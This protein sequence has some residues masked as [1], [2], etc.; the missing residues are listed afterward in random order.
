LSDG[1]IP[2]DA[3]LWAKKLAQIDEHLQGL[4]YHL[5]EMKKQVA[6]EKE[7]IESSYEIQRLA[8]EQYAHLTEFILQNLPARLP[9]R[10]AAV[11][12]GKEN[13]SVSSDVWSG[14]FSAH[15]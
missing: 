1:C 15:V 14:V 6:V 2:A 4:E 7:T 11:S 9:K 8:K 12:D 5:G 3:G 13:R 10:A